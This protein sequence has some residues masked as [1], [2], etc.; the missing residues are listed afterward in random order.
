MGRQ[1]AYIAGTQV[2]PC[3]TP[4]LERWHKQPY[5]EQVP[6]SPS[7]LGGKPARQHRLMRAPSHGVCHGAL[8]VIDGRSPAYSVSGCHHHCLCGKKKW[9]AC[10]PKYTWKPVTSAPGVSP[11][12][13]IG[14]LQMSSACTTCPKILRPSTGTKRGS[15]W[16]EHMDWSHC[17]LPLASTHREHWRTNRKGWRARRRAR[18][19]WGGRVGCSALLWVG[20]PLLQAARL[21]CWWRRCSEKT[22]WWHPSLVGFTIKCRWKR[23][24]VDSGGDDFSVEPWLMELLLTLLTFH[25]QLVS[26]TEVLNHWLMTTFKAHQHGPEDSLS[27]ALA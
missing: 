14:G 21:Q 26:G 10:Q 18:V 17:S 19:S 15:G 25:G 13:E 2:L 4:A 9:V 24:T 5:L 20:C 22:P 7:L 27:S 1:S 16:R 6:A 12:R 3:N 11:A 23:G 8:A